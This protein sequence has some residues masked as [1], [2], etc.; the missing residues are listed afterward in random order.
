LTLS[1][2]HTF[3]LHGNLRQARGQHEVAMQS[4]VKLQQFITQ[5]QL[6]KIN[7]T[8]VFKVDVSFSLNRLYLTATLHHYF[9]ATL[10]RK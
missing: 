2:P 1:Y 8:S 5:L 10:E 6:I 4:W 9:Y 7:K 3:N